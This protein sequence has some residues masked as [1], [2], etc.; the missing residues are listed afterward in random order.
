MDNHNI[1]QQ[2][3]SSEIPAPADEPFS[4][5]EKME[6]RDERKTPVDP[7]GQ[8]LGYSAH[9]IETY[10]ETN[11]APKTDYQILNERIDEMLRIQQHH[12]KGLEQVVQT[13]NWIATMLSGVAQMAQNMPGMGGMMARLMGVKGPKGG[14]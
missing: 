6:I 10:N 2:G 1:P 13:V 12:G 4:V 7:N 11:A 14:N 5:L 9:L 8:M 3:T